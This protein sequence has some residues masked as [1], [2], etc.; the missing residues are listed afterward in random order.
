MSKHEETQEI[1]D[2]EMKQNMALA[3][4][5]L[6]SVAAAVMNVPAEVFTTPPPVDPRPP[7]SEKEKQFRSQVDAILDKGWSS[8]DGFQTSQEEMDGIDKQMGTDNIHL[9]STYGEIT[10]LGSRQLFHYMELTEDDASEK[11]QPCTFMD[12]G[13]GGGKLLVQSY[14]ELKNVDRIIGIELSNDRYQVAK[15]AWNKVNK[16]AKQLRTETMGANEAS[17]KISKGDLYKIDISSATHIYVASLCFTE[18][19][20]ERLARKIVNEGENLKCVATLKAFP[21]EYEDRLGKPSIQYLEMSWT[22][23]KGT[24]SRVYFYNV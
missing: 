3:K 21:E 14:L 12:L 9:P 2:S 19:M 18:E 24:G 22:Q 8:V 17:L 23:Y 20:M 10:F 7:K 4:H 6:L 15:K 16:E 5:N 13:C 11:S 1:S